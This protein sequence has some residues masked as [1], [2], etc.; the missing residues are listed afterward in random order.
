MTIRYKDLIQ[1]PEKTLFSVFEFLGV[2][3][4]ALPSIIKRGTRWNWMYS[5]NSN[6]LDTSKV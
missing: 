5:D 2:S 6:T 3:S 4:E 1:E